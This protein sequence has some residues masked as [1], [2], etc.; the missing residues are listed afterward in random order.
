MSLGLVLSI[1]TGQIPEVPMTGLDVEIGNNPM[2]AVSS[3]RNL[4]VMMVEQVSKDLL[5][6]CIA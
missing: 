2:Q 5:P 3:L 1:G 6:G 4:G